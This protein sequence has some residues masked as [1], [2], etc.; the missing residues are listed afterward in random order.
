MGRVEL[1]FLSP[2]DLDDQAVAE[3]GALKGG[4]RS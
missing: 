4:A 2:D 3:I 1:T